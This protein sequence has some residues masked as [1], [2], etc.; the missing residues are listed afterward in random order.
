MSLD[1]SSRSWSLAMLRTNLRKWCPPLHPHPP[2]LFI[3]VVWGVTK[4]FG[5]DIGK[6]LMSK[7]M[8]KFLRARSV[9][10]LYPRHHLEC[11]FRLLS[12]LIT[13]VFFPNWV[14]HFSELL[15][16]I[17]CDFPRA[18]LESFNDFYIK[19]NSFCHSREYFYESPLPRCSVMES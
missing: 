10:G 13:L 18:A 17:V 9:T 6:T 3:M 15:Q 19:S 4:I 12:C 11:A 1:R 2:S 5:T 8:L 7:E 14:C 16:T